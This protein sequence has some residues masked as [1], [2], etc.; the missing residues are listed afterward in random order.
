M[1]SALSWQ[2][3]PIQVSGK[4]TENDIHETLN[5]KITDPNGKKTLYLVSMNKRKN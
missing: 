4:F 1:T 5:K 3:A 2:N